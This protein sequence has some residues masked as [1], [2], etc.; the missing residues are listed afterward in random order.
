MFPNAVGGYAKPPGKRSWL[1][2]A[3]ARCMAADEYFPRVTAHSL[4]HTAASLAISRGAN[5]MHVRK[6]LGHKS[7]AMTLDIY[8][9]LF[10]EDEAD[11]A[12]AHERAEGGKVAALWAEVG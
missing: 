11:V 1:E 5:V 9:D 6:M 2:G 12:E 7:A 10:G 8:S 3:V 4:R